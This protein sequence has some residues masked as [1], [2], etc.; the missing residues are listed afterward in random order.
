MPHAEI[1]LAS[2]THELVGLEATQLLEVPNEHV[3][4]RGCDGLMIC[5]RAAAR[6]RNDLVDDLELEQVR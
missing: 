6:F 5:V 2:T 1:L 4:H 3:V